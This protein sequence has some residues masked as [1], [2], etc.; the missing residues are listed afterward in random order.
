MHPFV[1]LF[2][3]LSTV[4]AQET[5]AGPSKPAR[6][7]LKYR[8]VFTMTN[9]AREEALQKTL[10]LMQRARRAGYNG[11]FVADSKF[12]KFQLQ[13]KSYARN[14]R[15][16]RQA[17]TEHEMELIVPVCPVGYAAEF[18]AADPNLAEGMPVRKAL[19]VV[20]DGKLTPRDDL[21]RLV[22]GSLEQWKR[23]S[24][25]GW[26][27]D[28]PGS[29]S[30]KDDEVTYDGKPTLRQDHSASKRG[31]VRVL[32]TIKVQPWHYYHVSVMAKTENCSSSDFRISAVDMAKGYPLNWQ[33]PPIR[34]TMDW[35]R[36][37]ATFASLD[38]SEVTLCL[39]SYNAKGGKIWWSDVQI[40]P[41]GL[42]N[43]IRRSSLPLAISSK[44]GKTIYTEGKDFSEVRDPKLGDDPN[45]G[46]FTYWHEPPTVTVPEG[47]R[48]QEG[49]R[50]LASYHFATLA[51]KSHQINCCLSEPKIYDLLAEQVKWVKETAQPDFY[52]MAHDEIRHCGWDDSCAAEH[53]LRPD[54]GRERKALRRD[55]RA[56]GL[57]ASRSWPGTTCSIHFTTPAK[58]AGCT[59]PRAAA[60]GTVP[61]RACP[62]ASWWPTGT[63]T[64]PRA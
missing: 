53:D 59:W 55:H 4:L 42:V 49:Q 14:V 30:C 41:G 19:F 13:D 8:W 43:V 16:L 52:M 34:K 54:P 2:L 37:H 7:Q 29:V 20:R 64:T 31:V 56:D 28:Q 18:L 36:L 12:D 61:G 38:N 45:P 26:T 23:G 1:I 5:G 11:I 32:Q 39:G 9:L 3:G 48:L 33:P 22:N 35:T 24:P 10:D 47:S 40:E 46:Y 51:G 25:V 21:A 50:V 62:P 6:V 63:R 60:R 17:C 57:R 15:R 44:D 58:R 27:V